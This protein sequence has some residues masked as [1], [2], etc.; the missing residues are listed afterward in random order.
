VQEARRLRDGAGIRFAN[1]GGIEQR[2]QVVEPQRLGDFVS[3]PRCLR[4]DPGR[5]IGIAEQDSGR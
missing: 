5:A 2:A 4:G 1:R 3:R